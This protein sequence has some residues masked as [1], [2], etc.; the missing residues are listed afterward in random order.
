MRWALLGGVLVVTGAIAFWILGGESAEE[1][2]ASPA[3][4]TP[5]GPIVRPLGQGF[6]DGV[7]WSWVNPFPRAMPSWRDAEMSPSGEVGMVGSAGRAARFDGRHLLRWPTGTEQDLNAIAFVGPVQAL[8]VGDGGTVQAL[9][10]SGVRTIET[11]IETDLHGVAAQGTLDG[12]AVGSDGTIVR[13]RQLEPVAI[14]TERNEDFLDVAFVGEQAWVVGTRGVIL[15]VDEADAVTVER[16]ASGVTLRAVGGCAG[17]HLY[18][19]GDDGRVLRRTREGRWRRLRIEG[20]EDWTDIGCVGSF[21]ALSGRSGGVL[22]RT[23]EDSVRLESGDPRAFFGLASFPGQADGAAY[24][25][26]DDGKFARVHRGQVVRLT[27]GPTQTFMGLGTL[28]GALVGVGLMGRMARWEEQ[29]MRPV[30]TGTDAA[31]AAVA[32]LTEDRLIAV[33]DHGQLRLIFWDRVEEIPA[34]GA[35]SWR[36]VVA[37]DGRL[38]AVGSGGHILRGAPGSFAVTRAPSERTLWGIDGTPED[39][40]AVGDGGQVWALRDGISAIPCP[41]T[42]TLRDVVR[43]GAQAWMVGDGG[44]ILRFEGGA[45]VTERPAGSGATLHA[46]DIGPNGRPLAAGEGGEVIERTDEGTWQS[47]ELNVGLG[48]RAIHRT[49]RHVY[50]A[51]AG[52]AILRH[53]RL[54][55]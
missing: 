2:I 38:L 32:L 53:A 15:A 43:Q 20:E 55:R 52:G 9:L 33:G 37:A 26:G 30:D 42:G 39:A 13:L 34:E 23:G 16:E 24:L 19:A 48:L 7:G 8:V 25:V 6:G 27:R 18:A 51:G 21:P 17:G 11:G 31:F 45:C 12:M 1:E 40:I 46:V 41:G 14:E 3:L 35:V 54:D 4:P 50:L 10:A 5:A 22:L 47:L 49:D 29:S 44:R 28:G 36:D